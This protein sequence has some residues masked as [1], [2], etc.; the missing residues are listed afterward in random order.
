MLVR[1]RAPGPCLLCTRAQ[2]LEQAVSAYRNAM[3][4]LRS[5][6]SDLTTVVQAAADAGENA[7]QCLLR[8]QRD[9]YQAGQMQQALRE[10]VAAAAEMGEPDPCPLSLQVSGG[11]M[12]AAEQG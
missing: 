11:R 6:E 8:V 9:C 2:L 3:L 4:L 5:D 10:A 12:R 1:L 7:A